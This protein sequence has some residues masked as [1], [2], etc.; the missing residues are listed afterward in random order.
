M[1][2]FEGRLPNYIHCL[3]GTIGT[4]TEQYKCGTQSL[5]WDY[6]DG[7]QLRIRVPVGYAPI[8]DGEVDQTRYACALYIFGTGSGGKLTVGL[9]QK[10]RGLLC[11]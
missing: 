6:R 1:I 11:V 7:S 3:G 2:T 8:T 5:K 9:L 10:R 4:T